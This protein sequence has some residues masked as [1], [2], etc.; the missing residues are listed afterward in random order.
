MSWPA[1]EF[2]S[3]KHFKSTTIC[4]NFALSGVTVLLSLTVFQQSISD[5]MP[6]TSLQ[7]PL[8]GKCLVTDRQGQIL[9]N[10]GLN[11]HL[12]VLLQIIYYGNQNLCTYIDLNWYLQ[13]YTICWVKRSQCSGLS[14]PATFSHFLCCHLV[15]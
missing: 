15:I 14:S 7:I 8:L 1:W 13:T 11:N 5:A 10:G 3:L 12:S 6:V 9:R 2:K 4:L